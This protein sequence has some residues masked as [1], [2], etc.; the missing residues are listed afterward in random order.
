MCVDVSFSCCRL[1]YDDSDDD[2]ATVAIVVDFVFTLI[3]LDEDSIQTENY[4]PSSYVRIY[5][6]NRGHLK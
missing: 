5:N 4:H 2:V 1:R 3:K 6:M